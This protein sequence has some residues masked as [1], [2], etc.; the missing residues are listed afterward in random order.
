MA[1]PVVETPELVAEKPAQSAETPRP[2]TPPLLDLA[3]R[4]AAKPAQPAPVAKS[5]AASPAP[6]AP[7]SLLDISATEDLDAARRAALETQQALKLEAMFA[8][9]KADAPEANPVSGEA[10]RGSGATDFGTARK[11]YDEAMAT[12]A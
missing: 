9:L 3:E 6:A 5:P 8:T 11:A 4:A 2:A 12:A 1:A 7:A 10:D